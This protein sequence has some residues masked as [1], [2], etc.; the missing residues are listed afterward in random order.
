ME[1]QK[2]N[3]WT[4]DNQKCADFIVFEPDTLPNGKFPTMQSVLSYYFYL[5]ANPDY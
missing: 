4:S 2:G 3:V 5:R 1:N